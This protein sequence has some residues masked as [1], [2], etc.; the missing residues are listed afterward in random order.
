MPAIQVNGA[1]LHYDDIAPRQSSLSPL[2]LVWLHGVLFNAELFH[3]V[4][5]GLP[6]YRHIAIDQRG[7]GR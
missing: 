2:T 4:I 6:N 7:H 5:A 3:T 1:E